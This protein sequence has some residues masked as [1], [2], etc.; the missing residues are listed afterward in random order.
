VD[1]A[2]GMGNDKGM[3][4]DDADMEINKDKNADVD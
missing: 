1:I 2:R 3:K 4:F